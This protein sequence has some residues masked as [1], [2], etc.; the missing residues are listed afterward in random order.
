MKWKVSYYNAAVMQQILELPKTLLARYLRTID[1]IE[2]FGANLGEPHTKLLVKVYLSYA[3][4]GE[5]G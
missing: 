1:L 3:L 2:Q 5:R 4:K